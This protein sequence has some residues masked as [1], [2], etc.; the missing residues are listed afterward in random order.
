M[1][2]A[3]GPPGNPANPPI[4]APPANAEPSST[5]FFTDSFS[6]S[7]PAASFATTDISDSVM[8]PSA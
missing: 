5:D 7:V 2:T 6:D 8:P 1:T 4:K 3:K